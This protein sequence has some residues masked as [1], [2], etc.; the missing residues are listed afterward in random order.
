MNHVKLFFTNANC[1]TVYRLGCIKSWE[2][3]LL[4]IRSIVS[5]IIGF[6]GQLYLRMKHLFCI[7]PKMLYLV[8]VN[9]KLWQL[10]WISLGIKSTYPI[11]SAVKL[12][13]TCS[14]WLINQFSFVYWFMHLFKISISSIQL[15]GSAAENTRLIFYTDMQIIG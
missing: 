1:E 15:K 3:P 10:G 4:R 11:L 12:V 8:I 6:L 13:G 2:T 14:K 5:H 9:Q 7:K